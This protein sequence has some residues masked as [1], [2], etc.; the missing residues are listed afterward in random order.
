[1]SDVIAEPIGSEEEIWKAH[2]LRAR[3]SRLSDANYCKKNALS[4]WRF[5][6]FKKKLGMTK[7]KAAV[8]GSK[9]GAFVEAIPLKF[10]LPVRSDD[11][12]A[13]FQTTLPDAR[14]L[15]EFVTALLSKR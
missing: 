6:S 11:R 7:P 13:G 2:I 8:S 5:T 15:A 14:W 3:A 10:E 9:P 1:M 12:S 4:V